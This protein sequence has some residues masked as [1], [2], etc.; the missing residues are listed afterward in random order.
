MR[1]LASKKHDNEVIESA[2]QNSHRVMARQA[3]RAKSRFLRAAGGPLRQT[4][5]KRHTIPNP[6]IRHRRPSSF[7]LVATPV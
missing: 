7:L 3:P 2:I 4:A 6:R 1:A 5:I